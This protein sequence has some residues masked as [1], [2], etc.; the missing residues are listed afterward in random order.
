MVYEMTGAIKRVLPPQTK[1]NF[2]FQAVH[3]EVRDGDYTD[4]V[5]LQASGDRMAD[6]ALLK[7]GQPVSV[8]FVIKGREWVSPQG[9]VKAFNTLKIIAVNVEGNAQPAS[10]PAPAAPA[11]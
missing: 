6:C 2:T 10:R 7:E 1:G 9:E 11:W 5:E 4:T 8:R 3:L